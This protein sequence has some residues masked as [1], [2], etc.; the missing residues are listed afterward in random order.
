MKEKFHVII[1]MIGIID[2][3]YYKN[4]GKSIV[5]YNQISCAF[6]A[7]ESNNIKLFLSIMVELKQNIY[8]KSKALF[9]LRGVIGFMF[10]LVEI[11]LMFSLNPNNI[12]NLI[13]SPYGGMILSGISGAC[14]S[15]VSLFLRIEEF[16]TS[17]QKSPFVLT[18]IILPF[19]GFIFGFVVTAL[20]QSKIINII[21]DYIMNSEG[22][23]DSPYIYILIGFISGFSERFAKGLLGRAEDVIGGQGKDSSQ[24]G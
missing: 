5:L 15:V 3:N 13:N 6:T 20:F 11:I 16:H 18:G 21:P 9:V 14:G 8:G 22:A 1:S 10:I 12:I 19:T 24:K 7:I 23:A 2:M 17:T 4:K